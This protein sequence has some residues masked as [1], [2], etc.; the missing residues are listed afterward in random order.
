MVPETDIQN[1]KEVPIFKIL[2]NFNWQT[3]TTGVKI[4]CPSIE[5]DDIHPGV[6]INK[7]NNTCRC[8]S[9]E[10]TFDT[11]LL[12][13]SLSEKVDGIRCSFPQAVKEILALDGINS[14]QASDTKI[15]IPSYQNGSGADQKK[16]NT[17][18]QHSTP[19]QGY[20]L[21]YLNSRGIFIY[22]TFMYKG[23]PYTAQT[24]DKMMEKETDAGRLRE[25]H[26]IK[27]HGTFYRGI[28][29]ILRQNRIKILHNY[30]C[31]VNSI[32]YLIDYDA[33]EDDDL[34]E[35]A[36][37]LT[38]SRSMLV[39]KSLDASHQKQ[40]LGD[41]TWNW[42]AEGIGNSKGNIYICEGLEDALSFTQNREKSISLNSV[43]HLSEFMEF[44][45][46]EYHPRRGQ[47]FIMAFDHDKSGEK[48][49]KRMIEFFEQYNK[50][51]KYPYH[52]S[53][54]NYPEQFHD[55]NDY[56]ISKV[57]V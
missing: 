48:A 56:W 37:F 52:Y 41:I 11:I 50:E 28:R 44:L 26:E 20:E 4:L 27:N 35:N 40:A 57:S 46:D 39:K 19:L 23:K 9:C 43:A 17:V 2:D 53:T 32:I 24:I 21:N 33:D 3:D 38:D 30:Y 18:L 5:H 8:F 10:A 54:C 13:R 15:Y 1:A 47:K 31:G 49:T 7:K 45:A 14:T 29:N 36:S 25:L 34:I 22:D 51:H 16:Y 55:I 12:Y 42:I 6:A